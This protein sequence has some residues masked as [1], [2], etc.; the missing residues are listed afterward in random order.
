MVGLGDLPGGAFSSGAG[1]I[2][3]DGQI[4]VGSSITSHGTDVVEAVIW[5]SDSGPMSLGTLPENSGSFA[6]AASGEGEFVVGGVAG[7]LPGKQAFRWS[8]MT[9]MVGLGR[10]PG[11]TFSEARDVSAD[12]SIV[13]GVSEFPATPF[14]QS[15]QAMLW[16]EETGMIGLGDLPGGTFL[17]MANAVSADGQL[18]VGQSSIERLDFPCFCDVYDAFLWDAVHGMRSLKGILSQDFGI[19]L[20]GWELSAATAISPDGTAIVGRGINP[21][22]NQEAWLAIIP[23]PVTLMMMA[24][25]GFAIRRRNNR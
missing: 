9:G 3:D 2:S 24:M 15:T 11:G 6:T 10:L 21:D 20:T 19:D 23:E 13:V 18:V 16:S 22:G 4:I 12:G 5:V 7:G 8:A 1:G 25:G 17:S 14:T